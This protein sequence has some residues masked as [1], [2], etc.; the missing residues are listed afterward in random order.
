MCIAYSENVSSSKSCS[1]WLSPSSSLSLFAFW[2][3]SEYLP[4]VSS[5][6]SEGALP[7]FFETLKNMWN[8]GLKMY[9]HFIPSLSIYPSISILFCHFP[10]LAMTQHR[11]FFSI[12]LGKF[13]W[14]QLVEVSRL[15]NYGRFLFR[16]GLLLTFHF[17]HLIDPSTPL[18][19]SLKI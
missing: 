18:R 10:E 8:W 2:T 17:F 14:N 11:L 1:L 4:R 15:S 3:S 7:I 9:Q 19:L 16:I 13:L 12:L 6:G 5:I